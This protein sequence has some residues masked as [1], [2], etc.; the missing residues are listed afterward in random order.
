ML[1]VQTGATR[2]FIPSIY[3]SVSWESDIFNRS[4]RW[5]LTGVIIAVC[6]YK[7]CP[8]PGDVGSPKLPEHSVQLQPV[9]RRTFGCSSQ[10]PLQ[11]SVSYREKSEQP[12]TQDPDAVVSFGS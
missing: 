7:F 5:A 6:H 9:L 11:Q 12:V 10:E 2:N 3:S 8:V 4:F 1:E